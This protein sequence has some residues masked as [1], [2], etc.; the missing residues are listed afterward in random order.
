TD[1]L[2]PQHLEHR[3]AL[4]FHPLDAGREAFLEDRRADGEGIGALIAERLDPLGRRDASRHD[5]IAL[6]P[7]PAPCCLDEID[8][9]CLDSTISKKI[10]PRAAGRRGAL[11]VALDIGR[12]AA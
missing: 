11:A 5:E 6:L 10:D 9:I 12:A 7:K 8:G 3:F 4:P 1:N 2:R